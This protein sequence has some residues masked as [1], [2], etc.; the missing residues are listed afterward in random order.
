MDART[1][2]GIVATLSIEDLQHDF[3]LRDLRERAMRDSV[4]RA[5]EQ[6][7]AIEA[8]VTGIAAFKCEPR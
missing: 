6:L 3:D 1:I 5:E 8:R 2:L 4:I 7:D